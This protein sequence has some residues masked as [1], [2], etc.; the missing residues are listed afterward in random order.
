VHGFYVAN[1]TG[2]VIYGRLDREMKAKKTVYTLTLAYEQVT[3]R[4]KAFQ[5][6]V[7]FPRR[8]ESKRILSLDG[9]GIDPNKALNVVSKIKGLVHSQ[10]L[11]TDKDR[12]LRLELPN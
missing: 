6:F 4:S 2:V 9:I 10:M 7:F 12:F 8:K 11:D 1:Y 5:N 3:T